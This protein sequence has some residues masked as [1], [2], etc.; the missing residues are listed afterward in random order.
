[1]AIGVK[2]NVMGCVPKLAPVADA[3]LIV[4]AVLPT[5]VPVPLAFKTALLLKVQLLMAETSKVAPAAMVI[6][7]ELLIEPVLPK[8]STPWLMRV[9]PE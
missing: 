9:L 6:L 7:G 4:A 3:P 2:I 1:V 8:A 5:V